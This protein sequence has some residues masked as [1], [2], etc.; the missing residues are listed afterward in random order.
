[1]RVES[2]PVG[3]VVNLQSRLFDILGGISG[4]ENNSVPQTRYMLNNVQAAGI[5]PGQPWSAY[6]QISRDAQEC[7]QNTLTTGAFIELYYQRETFDRLFNMNKKFAELQIFRKD[8]NFF[9][10]LVSKSLRSPYSVIHATGLKQLKANQTWMV[11]NI[12]TGNKADIARL[13]NM[14]FVTETRLNRYLC[15][16]TGE[17]TQI[18]EVWGFFPYFSNRSDALGEI[19]FYFHHKVT[20]LITILSLLLCSFK[21]E[22]FLELIL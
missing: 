6:N 5:S 17:V 14:S 18:T 21:V 13:I 9:S 10:Q 16:K 19:M 12:K 7:N 4:N 20:N 22:S 1:M 3:Y 8:G 11:H 15:E 2:T